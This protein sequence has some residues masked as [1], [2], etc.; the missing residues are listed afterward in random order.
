MLAEEDDRCENLYMGV[1]L[2]PEVV[3]AGH[4]P[5]VGAHAVAAEEVMA[6]C[7]L[8]QRE[9]MTGFGRPAIEHVI[10]GSVPEGRFNVTSDIDLCVLL[11]DNLKEPEYK[12]VISGV[13]S[14][15]RE[16]LGVYHIVLEAKLVPMS[17]LG[18]GREDDPLFFHYLSK[19]VDPENE[20]YKPEWTSYGMEPGLFNP[21]DREPSR[22]EA[23]D[24]LIDYLAAKLQS[25]VQP[26]CD[27]S[28]AEKRV[29]RAHELPGR[30]IAKLKQYFDAYHRPTGTQAETPKAEQI[31]IFEDPVQEDKPKLVQRA[32]PHPII[33][34]LPDTLAREQMRELLRRKRV[35]IEILED[36]RDG[37]KRAFSRYQRWYEKALEDSVPRAAYASE[38]LLKLV[39][40]E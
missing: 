29:Q 24:G 13:G 28:E 4:F 9:V 6:R 32:K 39:R 10:H 37:D 36:I 25:F 8:L 40:A 2:N 38:A 18:L 21:Y 27:A 26:P 12:R 15:G 5:A 23:E 1:V 17:S 20:N 14:I 3:R 34:L 11:T 19:L 33:G 35:G 7:L 31:A 16:I 22:R 30:S